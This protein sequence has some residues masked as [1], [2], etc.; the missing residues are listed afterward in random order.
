M[1]KSVWGLRKE[2]GGKDGKYAKI[3]CVLRKHSIRMRSDVGT[4]RIL[5][6]R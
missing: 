6:N 1:G 4:V 2:R 5:S 3:C